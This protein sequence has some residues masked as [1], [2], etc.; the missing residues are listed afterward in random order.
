MGSLLFAVV[1]FYWCCRWLSVPRLIVLILSF[2]FC[3][4][5]ICCGI[6]LF[7]LLVL[8]WLCVALV[9]I[10]CCVWLLFYAV[11]VDGGLVLIVCLAVT[12]VCVVGVVFMLFGCFINLLYVLFPGLLIGGCCAISCVLC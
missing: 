10:V 4:F 7:L 6:G 1:G 5:Y 11:D 12:V 2:F 3:L 8:D 9:G